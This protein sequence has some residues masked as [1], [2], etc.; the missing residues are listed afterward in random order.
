MVA[1]EDFF[2]IPMKRTMQPPQTVIAVFSKLLPNAEKLF[3]CR[4]AAESNPVNGKT[5]Q[6]SSL[7]SHRAIKLNTHTE[8]ILADSIFRLLIGYEYIR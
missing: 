1:F 2:F 4:V 7:L 8:I 5:V 3:M 6:T